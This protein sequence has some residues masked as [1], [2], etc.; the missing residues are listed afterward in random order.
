[1]AVW[2]IMAVRKFMA[3]RKIMAVRKFMA[4]KAERPITC[5]AVFQH[6]VTEPGA[7]QSYAGKTY[8]ELHEAAER[9]PYLCSHGIAS[10]A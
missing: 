3:L 9:D 8:G 7:K 5:E 6:Y 2:K 4:V 10:R 1:M